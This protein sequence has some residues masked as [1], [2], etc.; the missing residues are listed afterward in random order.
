MTSF[1]EIRMP[2]VPVQLSTV[3]GPE[4]KTNVYQT[5]SGY[6]R[7]NQ[8]WANPL[9]R[10]DAKLKID[11]PAKYGE[12]RAFFNVVRGKGIGFRF[13][14]PFDY[15]SKT[16]GVTA[17]S[18]TDQPLG[19]G[20]GAQTTFQLKKNYTW[21]AYTY[22]RT[23]VKPVQGTLTIAFDGV[24]QMTGFTVNPA[25]G[26]VTFSPAP[27]LG[28]VITAGFEFDT[29][30]RLDNDMFPEAYGG[31]TGSREVALSIVELRL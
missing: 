25:T 5:F 19:T 9:R 17:G 27:S 7:R 26:I 18:P 4:Y 8:N 15:T 3:G 11:S 30:V 14:D 23:I 12:L 29:P 10:W 2:I 22:T 28:V 20:T 16:D 1:Y 31:G 24:Q 21:N 6:E 13:K